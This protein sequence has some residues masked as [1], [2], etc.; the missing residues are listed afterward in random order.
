MNEPLN[1]QN[2][3]DSVYR[4]PSSNP[5]IDTTGNHAA[6]ANYGIIDWFKK[7]L[8]NYV[9]FSGRARR[10]EYWYFVLIQFILAIVAMTLD[11]IIFDTPGA[12][13]YAVVIF[14]LLLPGIAVLVR[15]LH[16][17]GR[18]GWWFWIGLLPVIGSIILL[19]FLASDTKQESN[20]WGAPAK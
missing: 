20:Q 17:T 13:L 7:C 5:I 12:L 8:R 18:S 11:Y 10:K 2:T 19:V 9:N 14:G 4:P 3:T 15:R 16:D 6:E 1:N